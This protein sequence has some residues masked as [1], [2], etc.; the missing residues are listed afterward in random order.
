MLCEVLVWKTQLNEISK[1]ILLY[2]IKSPL[3]PSVYSF[4]HLP[5]AILLCSW[6]SMKEDPENNFCKPKLSS[7]SGTSTVISIGACVLMSSSLMLWGDQQMMI[8]AYQQFLVDAGWFFFHQQCLKGVK[9]LDLG[10]R[11]TLSVEA[12]IEVNI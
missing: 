2:R 12:V 9:M 5:K 6:L 11:F 3:Q 7:F 8:S 1:I 10:T 4:S